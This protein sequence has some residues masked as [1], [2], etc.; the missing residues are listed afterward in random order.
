[1]QNA[2]TNGLPV[3]RI[4]SSAKSQV[5]YCERSTCSAGS[6]IS[7]AAS[8]SAS[9]PSSSGGN[10]SKRG[11]VFQ[12]FSNRIRRSATDVRD[13]LSNATVRICSIGFLLTRRIERTA[14]V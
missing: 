12:Y 2:N 13:E 10:E 3:N 11:A 4:H 9:I 6:P 7:S 14:R 5:I 8:C 1:A